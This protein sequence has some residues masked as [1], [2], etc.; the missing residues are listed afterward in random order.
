VCLQSDSNERFP[1]YA[2][3][4]VRYALVVLKTEDRKPVAI[5]YIDWAI[6]KFDDEGG[7]DEEDEQRN[8]ELGV[9]LLETFLR[10]TQRSGSLVDASGKFYKKQYDY[11][12][13][14]KPSEKIVEAIKDSIFP[15]KGSPLRLV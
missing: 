7:L 5:K 9:S 13:R 8:A 2:G 1:E 11:E 14:W 10:G 12:F 6:L 15:K 4:R 3:K